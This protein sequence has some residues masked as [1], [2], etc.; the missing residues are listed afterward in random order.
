ML[1]VLSRVQD[2]FLLELLTIFRN[3]RS[4]RNWRDFGKSFFG[5][6]I[7]MESLICHLMLIKI[8]SSNE[9]SE[10]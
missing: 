7:G 9:L 1:Q 4:Q 2:L 10:K 6:K 8:A 3:I 5:A